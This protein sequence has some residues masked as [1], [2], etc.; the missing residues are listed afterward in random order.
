M[1][2]LKWFASAILVLAP[3]SPAFSQSVPTPVTQPIKP[4]VAFP[5]DSLNAE[6]LPQS[7]IVRGGHS[8]SG[9]S[10]IKENHSGLPPQEFYKGLNMRLSPFFS[11][12]KP[13]PN[14][15]DKIWKTIGTTIGIGCAGIAAYQ[16]IP[17]LQ[18]KKPHYSR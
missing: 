5:V 14:P 4:V 7:V 1:K 15:D 6:V 11:V 10:Y 13:K 3:Y 12:Q 17:L 18:G 8:L 16:A 2:Q 9:N